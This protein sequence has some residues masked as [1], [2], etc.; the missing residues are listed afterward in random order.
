MDSDFREIGH[1]GG[2]VTFCLSKADSGQLSMSIKWSSNRSNP[3]AIAGVYALQNGLPVAPIRFGGIG[4]SWSPPPFDGCFTVIIGSDSEG[5]FGHSCPQ[6]DGYW[7]GSP[8][9]N[10]CPYCGTTVPMN[11]CLS[12][13]QLKYIREYVDVLAAAVS[14]AHEQLPAGQSRDVVI[15]MD[16]VADA[17]TSETKPDFYFCEEG[18]QNQFECE[19]CH[20]FNDIIGRFAYCSVCG[21]RNDLMEA[22]KTIDEIRLGIREGGSLPTAIRNS[23][24]FF[25]SFVSQAVKEL[26]AFVPMTPRR[27]GKLDGRSFHDFRTVEASLKECLD[28]N[29][30]SGLKPTDVEL[31]IKFFHRRHLH[32]HNGGV[33][34]QRYLAESGDTSVRLRQELREDL[35]E[36]H[37]LLNILSRVFSNIHEQFSDILP[38]SE[39]TAS[40]S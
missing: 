20:A 31:L 37:E 4:E 6:C 19:R 29:I 22:K 1:C 11:Q 25:D 33:V 10:Y 28:I 40:N 13:A 14:R 38:P 27:R 5:Q 3:A 12:S 9:P 21:G 15:D 30:S 23:I 8:Y 18:Q 39:T 26:L 7:R 16:E 35:A 32:E 34:D 17:V 2:Q 24:S 36:V